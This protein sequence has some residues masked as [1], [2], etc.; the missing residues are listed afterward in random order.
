[1]LVARHKRRDERRTHSEALS[2]PT[3]PAGYVQFLQRHAGNRAVAELIERSRAIQ[4]HPLLNA[5]VQ[6][7]NQQGTQIDFAAALNAALNPPN[8]PNDLSML[9]AVVCPLI[10]QVRRRRAVL[11]ALENSNLAPVVQA[12]TQGSPGFLVSSFDPLRP[13]V[14]SSHSGNPIDPDPSLVQA[15]Y[16]ATLAP[17]AAG[18]PPLAS[19][20]GVV[21][22]AF[23]DWLM[24][25]TTSHTTGGHGI[26][27]PPGVGVNFNRVAS[28]LEVTLGGV[29]G[30]AGHLA[31]GRLMYEP[32]AERWYVSD[33]YALEYEVVNVPAAAAHPQYA[34]TLQEI[35]R[36]QRRLAN[37]SPGTRT[38]RLQ[39]YIGGLWGRMARGH[40]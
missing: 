23:W 14:R 38:A 12:Y 3:T 6:Q 18:G 32:F 28:Y 22:P 7:S 30:P 13:W 20:Q 5:S 9:G 4:R 2:A 15:P 37:K 1:M 16:D 29:H 40:L 25:S 17:G 10:D 36:L 11:L 27:L 34:I 24:S 26:Q 31:G 39:Q 35:A 8:P 21:G 19:A 33:H